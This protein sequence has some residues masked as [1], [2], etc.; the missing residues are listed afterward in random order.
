MSFLTKKKIRHLVVIVFLSLS[1]GLGLIQASGAEMVE[2]PVAPEL[3]QQVVRL[4]AEV[5]SSSNPEE[6]GLP[7]DASIDL[8]EAW[9][10]Y[11]AVAS[12]VSPGTFVKV[13]LETP[14]GTRLE[15]LSTEGQL[16]SLVREIGF[17]LTVG[18]MM[19]LLEETECRRP[20]DP[21]KWGEGPVVYF[22]PEPTPVYVPSAYFGSPVVP[23]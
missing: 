1:P 22:G 11:S 21:F 2:S 12:A 3:R 18:R 8:C 4:L 13:A 15:A 17:S 20:G 16:V 5:V 14:L 19:Y 6:P 7:P 9:I 23:G 10:A